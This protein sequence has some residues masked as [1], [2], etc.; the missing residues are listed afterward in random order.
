MRRIGVRFSVSDTPSGWKYREYRGNRIRLRP[1]LALREEQRKRMGLPKGWKRPCQPLNREVLLR[2]SS[3]IHHHVGHGLP[4][5][6]AKWKQAGIRWNARM[7]S[8][9]SPK[10]KWL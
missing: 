4:G 10:H 5:D 1:T 9:I 8:R 7:R 3:V 6:R 2:A